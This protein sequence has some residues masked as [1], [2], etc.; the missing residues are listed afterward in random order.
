MRRL[1]ARP[2]RRAGIAIPATPGETL[3]LLSRLLHENC[4]AFWYPACIDAVRG[5]YTLVPG[6]EARGIGRSIERGVVSQARM[7]WFFSRLMTGGHGGPSHLEAAAHGF[8][9]LRDRMWDDLHGGVYWTVDARTGR[10]I[11]DGKH[12]YG[13]SFALFALSRYAAVSGDGEA[14]SLARTLA[15][16]VH[17]KSHDAVHGGYL[18]L[19][20]RDWSPW[21]ADERNYLSDVPAGTKRYNSHLHWFEALIEYADQLGDDAARPWLAELSAILTDRVVRHDHAVCT[22]AHMTDWSPLPGPVNYGHDMEAV[23]LLRDAERRTGAVG[24]DRIARHVALLSTAHRWGWDDRD[25]GYFWSGPPGAAAMDRG[26]NSWVQ[27]EALVSALWLYLETGEADYA[28]W[29]LATLDWIV[30]VQA[31]WTR[32]EWH[33]EIAPNGR[34]TGD[35][36]DGWKS[37]YHDGRALMTCIELLSGRGGRA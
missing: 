22:D 10:P 4:L 29:Y 26:K 15:H 36:G 16:L 2:P 34:P 35:K 9:F 23:W 21:T 5:G 3:P 28:D 24:A 1:P 27:A 25:G 13:Q 6:R 33:C 17:E 31:D 20:R 14:E 30:N 11:R 8:R 18:E 12:L 32:G 19:F 37:A 7:V